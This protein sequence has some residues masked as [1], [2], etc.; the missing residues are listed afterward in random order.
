[1]WVRVVEKWVDFERGVRL[2][3]LSEIRQSVF[4][5]GSEQGESSH[6]VVMATTP[7]KGFSSF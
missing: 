5:M 1:M 6:L 2:V 4:N 3:A 7:S